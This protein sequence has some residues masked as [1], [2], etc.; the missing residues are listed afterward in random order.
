[1]INSKYKFNSCALQFYN[2]SGSPIHW[3]DGRNESQP[4][5]HRTVKE[6]ELKGGRTPTGSDQVKK[7]KRNKNTFINT[8]FTC[9]SKQCSVFSNEQTQSMTKSQAT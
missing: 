2:I 3:G 5:Q 7:K 9:A 8:H 6:S 1:M 4:T